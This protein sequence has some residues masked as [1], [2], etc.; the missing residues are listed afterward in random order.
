LR[1]IAPAAHEFAGDRAAC[2]PR[3]GAAPAA[4][5]PDR[6]QNR[7]R[8]ME[9]ATWAFAAGVFVAIALAL[10]CVLRG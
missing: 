3:A 4:A 7:D 6:F 1:Q 9:L 2:A 10:W 5:R 8:L